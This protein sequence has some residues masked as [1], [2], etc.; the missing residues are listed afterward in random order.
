MF[1]VAWE[2]FGK[3]DRI[4]SKRKAFKT[5]DSRDKFIEKL[6]EKDSFYRILGVR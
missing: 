5:V 2:E 1:E 4:V 6:C 3:N